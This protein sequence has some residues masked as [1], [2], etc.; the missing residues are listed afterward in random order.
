[1]SITTFYR[2]C[3][4]LPVAVPGFL[5]VAV[6]LFGLRDPVGWVGELIAYSLIYG[7]V[8]YLALASWAMWWVGGRT[9]AEIRRLMYRA[10]LV[11]L[12]VFVPIAL[13]VG[14]LVGAPGP[15]AAVALLGAVVIVLLGYSYV[16]LT[17]LL[18]AQLGSRVNGSERTV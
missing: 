3:I 11:M 10:P 14:V 7:G 15:W 1:M 4:W 9:E 18:R 2:L 17:V 5:I 16:G 8:P 12:G 13:L 6:N